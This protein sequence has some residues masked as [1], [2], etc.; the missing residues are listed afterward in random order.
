[1]IAAR[2]ERKRRNTVT[3]TSNVHDD[4]SSDNRNKKEDMVRG[5][6]STGSAGAALYPSENLILCV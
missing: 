4:D 5:A 1:M 2:V 3:M 6:G